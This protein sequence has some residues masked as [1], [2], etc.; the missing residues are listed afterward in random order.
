M[1]IEIFL[2]GKSEDELIDVNNSEDCQEESIGYSFKS[3]VKRN[4]QSRLYTR[5]NK[6]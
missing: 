3:P 2:T 6:D 4:F 5:K 1:N